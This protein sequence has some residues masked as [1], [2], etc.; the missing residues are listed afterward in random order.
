MLF[1]FSIAFSIAISIIYGIFSAILLSTFAWGLWAIVSLLISLLWLVPL[2]LV[3]IGIVNAASGKM[4][5]L[6][7]IG[8]FTIIK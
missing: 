8:K 4:K 2:V 6:P 1:L 3:I 7:I 5:E